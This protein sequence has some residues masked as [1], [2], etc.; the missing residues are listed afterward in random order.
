MVT[1]RLAARKEAQAKRGGAGIRREGV[2]GG[3]AG[4]FP[5]YKKG[6]RKR[7]MEWTAL[8]AVIDNNSAAFIKEPFLS[9][10]IVLGLLLLLRRTT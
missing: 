8:A 5:F 7:K 9:L 10:L 2:A 4:T 1:A 6:G 3:A